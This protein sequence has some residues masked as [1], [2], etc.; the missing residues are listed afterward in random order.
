MFGKTKTL[1]LNVLKRK[2]P[3][4]HPAI[5]I[6]ETLRYPLDRNFFSGQRFPPFQHLGRECQMKVV[7][8]ESLGTY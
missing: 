2:L 4:F 3:E 5:N 8:R 1:N 7:E 6:R